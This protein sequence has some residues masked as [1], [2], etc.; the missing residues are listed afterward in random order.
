MKRISREHQYVDLR[1]MWVKGHLR[2]RTGGQK[3]KSK[4]YHLLNAAAQMKLETEM[5][6]E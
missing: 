4:S 1:G 3:S 5:W 2:I 6:T